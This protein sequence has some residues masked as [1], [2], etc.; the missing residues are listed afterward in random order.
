MSHRSHC[1]SHR[2]RR[3][4]QQCCV[5]KS[6][7]CIVGPFIPYTSIQAGVNV[8]PNTGGPDLAQPLA[9]EPQRLI[10]T[11]TPPALDFNRPPGF[12]IASGPYTHANASFTALITRIFDPVR[13][14]VFALR[15]YIHYRGTPASTPM[16]R[17][18]NLEAKVRLSL[19][20]NGPVEAA[21][22]SVPLENGGIPAGGPHVIITLFE[23]S[24]SPGGTLAVQLNVYASLQLL[25]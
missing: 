3:Q 9:F 18:L 8:N 4:R 7:P 14:V 21:V 10:N 6:L 22:N 25:R 16:T 1:R 12:S 5:P 2:C 24:S 23:M 17:I 19:A 13:P 20:A 11:L 15:A